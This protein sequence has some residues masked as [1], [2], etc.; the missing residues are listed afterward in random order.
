MMDI[1][2]GPRQRLYGIAIGLIWRRW[3]V[4]PIARMWKRLRG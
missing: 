4:K 3:C 2:T 1:D